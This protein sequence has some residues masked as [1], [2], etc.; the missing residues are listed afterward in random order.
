MIVGPT[1]THTADAPAYHLDRTFLFLWRWTVERDGRDVKSGV[2]FSRMAARFAARSVLRA[3]R[4]QR[5]TS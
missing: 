5:G 2:A 3:T 1:C 4:A